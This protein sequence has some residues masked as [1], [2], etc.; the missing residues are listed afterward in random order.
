MKFIVR[1]LLM[2]FLILSFLSCS[3]ISENGTQKNNEKIEKDFSQELMNK[4]SS[5]QFQNV[6]TMMIYLNDCSGCMRGVKKWGCIFWKE[7]NEARGIYFDNS[8]KAS[9]EFS[10][11]L[12]I[13]EYYNLYK[14]KILFEKLEEPKIALLHYRYIT[15]DLFY[16][17][18]K[19]YSS[20]RLSQFQRY[21]N[22]DKEVFL[23]IF[24]I[25]NNIFDKLF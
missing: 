23:W 10:L 24:I 15:I 9:R 14:E 25:E 16:N 13:F 6:D 7:N 19:E 3:L 11:G 18:E 17:R 22:M 21:S 8:G 5:L 12:D 2:F 4:F 20:G 1:I